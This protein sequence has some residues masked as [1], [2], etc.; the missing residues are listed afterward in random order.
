MKTLDLSKHD[1]KDQGLANAYFSLRGMI[2]LAV[3]ACVLAALLKLAGW[4]TLH[5]MAVVVIGPAAVILFACLL[6]G[7]LTVEV[8]GKDWIAG[9]Q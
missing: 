9:R 6:V 8:L 4:H 2:E 5:W 7:G 3:C 1:S